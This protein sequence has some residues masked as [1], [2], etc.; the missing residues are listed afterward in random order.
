[1]ASYR[2]CSTN[3]PC[4]ASSWFS[5]LAFAGRWARARDPE[6]DSGDAEPA[7]AR[8]VTTFGRVTGVV[9]KRQRQISG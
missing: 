5:V 1:M 6:K 8:A 4:Q 7:G 3:S 2:A 9:P